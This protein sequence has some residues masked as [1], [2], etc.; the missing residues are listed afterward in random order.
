[1]A[2]EAG[3]QRLPTRVDELLAIEPW[4]LPALVAQARPA[5]LADATRR[6]ALKMLPADGEIT[7]LD[8]RAVVKLGSLAS[9]LR[10]AERESWYTVTIIDL[11]QAAVANYFRAGLL[12]TK[13]A[14]DLL[15]P[16]ELQA[17]V[18]HEMAHE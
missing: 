7:A 12:V 15:D 4:R 13:P 11:P 18:A 2:A 1:M 6:A 3:A 8:E 9:V 5:P 16:D 10:V 14:L 17:L